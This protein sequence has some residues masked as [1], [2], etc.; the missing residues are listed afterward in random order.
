MA[1]RSRLTA[2]RAKIREAHK[3]LIG[4]ASPVKSARILL[5]E[6][7]ESAARFILDGLKQQGYVVEH[8]TNGKNGLFLAATEQY[9]VLIIDR[10]LPGLDGLSI[11]K[12][13]RAAGKHAPA[14]FLTTMS[15]INDRVEGLDA[16]ADDYLVKPFAFAELLAR[17]TA[18]SR[19]PP[20]NEAVMILR[21]GDLEIDLL[22]RT[23]R[24]ADRNIEL[25]PQEFRLLEYLV[26]SKG[27]VVTRS[28]L[29]EDVWEFD[30]DP[31]TNVVEAYI[32]RLRSKI[33]KGFDSELL[34]TVRGVGYSLHVDV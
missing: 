12:M 20:I 28:M 27:R 26:R 11:V 1:F 5:I 10:M 31:Q 3:Q 18:L 15:G 33:D 7:D 9:D 34:R 21:A 23:V 25:T 2:R 29:L 13:L 24:R 8:V 17:I 14:I 30:F 22:K 4:H 32:S 6:D 19:R 16:G